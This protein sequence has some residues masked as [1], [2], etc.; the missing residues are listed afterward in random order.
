[1]LLPALADNPSLTALSLWGNP[2][3][4]AG[5]SELARYLGG[6]KYL[7]LGN[8]RVG[9]EGARAL[10]HEL[11]SNTTLTCLD[12]ASNPGGK[13]MGEA[14]LEALSS[15]VTLCRLDLR[16]T[17]VPEEL[18]ALLREEKNREEPSRL[19]PLEIAL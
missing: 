19:K 4:D 7:N 15:N 1:M 6:L 2:L 17:S 12:L 9:Q 11:A 14:M 10:C 18:Q 8:S 5:A 3:G 13:G 16:G